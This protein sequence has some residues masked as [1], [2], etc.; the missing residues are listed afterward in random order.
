MFKNYLKIAFRNLLKQKAYSFINIIGL[1][2]ALACCFVVLLY[3]LDEL[4]YDRYHKNA[5]RIFRIVY[6]N[7]SYITATPFPLAPTLR[8]DFPEVLKTVRIST[9]SLLIKKNENWIE[10]PK[11]ICADEAFF[12]VFTLPL[13][14]GDPQNVLND[15]FS[16]VI[17]KEMAEKYFGKQEPVGKTLNIQ[18]EKELYDMKVTGI[19]EHFPKNSHFRTD[20][21][22][23]MSV[24]KEVDKTFQK[25][26]KA[27]FGYPISLLSSWD[28]SSFYT[29]LLLPEGYVAS[30]LEIKLPEFNKRHFGDEKKFDFHLQ[31][32]TD[33]H[34]SSKTRGD[35]D[36]QG[37]MRN[38]YLFSTIALFILAIACINFIILTT[39][40]S[41]NRAK[42]IGLRK[43]IGANRLDLIKQV[44]GESIV[45]AFIA[46][47]IA[48][49]FVE[50]LLPFVNQLLG[51]ELAGN[52]FQNWQCAIGFLSITI[53]VGIFSGSYIGFYLSRFQ[54]VEIFKSMVIRGSSKSYF[55]KVLVIIQLSV[56]IL[57]LVCSL[58]FYHQLH[59]LHNK[60][61]GFS[62]EHLLSFYITNA[63]F[64][65]SYQAFK[66]EIKSNP[67]VLSVSAAFDVPP[68]ETGM[69][70]QVATPDNPEEKHEMKWL[71]VDYDYFETLR[72]KLVHG[73]TFSD[74][75]A[76]E[77]HES[78]IL[79]QSAI[80][81]LGLKESIGKVVKSENFNRPKKII[82]VIEDFHE[83]SLHG[84][85]PPMVFS[86]IPSQIGQ[87]VIRIRPDNVSNTI[88]YIRNTWRQFNPDETFA[89]SFIEE[90]YSKFYRSEEKLGRIISAFTILTILV[91]CL[92][93]FGLSMFMAEQRTKEIGIR[94]VLGASV[95]SVVQ[96]LTKEFIKWVLLANL[97]AWPIAYYAMNKWLQ[98]FAYRINISWWVFVLA[99]GIA[100]V[101]ALLT[102]SWQVIRT[103]IA[104]PMEALRYE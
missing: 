77:S 3:V 31:S 51:K 90:E 82:G 6:G 13:I 98:N 75:Y 44:L 23:S 71:F 41:S 35:I 52:Y 79:N 70:I 29:Y 73:R 38:I 74:K 55:R 26:S 69:S 92:G 78:V 21:I 16:V 1:A 27:R 87:I 84:Q 85:I 81:E 61:L 62:I 56:F 8:N 42:E 102:V 72:V 36:E 97:I 25:I 93:L 50:V 63:E 11:S 48:V 37:S 40:R 17:T 9:T 59:F 58:L 18:I 14:K 54:P 2:I 49:T 57:M 33:I 7:E 88:E 103:A 20:F 68:T 30:E 91:A 53:A 60:D 43:V 66:H 15:P 104:N 67:N 99:G 45:T 86:C 24:V 95:T 19:I 94:K 100:L 101:I 5:D 12:E 76:N 80:K 46:L 22:A 39:A 64:K 34:L 96:L 4:S 28:A 89:F 10:E 32:L 83:G 65:K 47:P